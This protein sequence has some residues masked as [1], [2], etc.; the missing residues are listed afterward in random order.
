[1]R[2]RQKYPHSAQWLRPNDASKGAHETRQA[3]SALPRVDRAARASTGQNRLQ[4]LQS[5]LGTL[6]V[7][8]LHVKLRAQQLFQSLLHGLPLV[9]ASQTLSEHGEP[10]FRQLL[11]AN[12]PPASPPKQ[13]SGRDEAVAAREHVAKGA[14][15]LELAHD[16]DELF[17]VTRRD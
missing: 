1:M 8:G 13:V 3:C 16:L 17:S 11:V 7:D 10:V 4:L 12:R 6:I 5:L 9:L 15:S 14:S 2:K